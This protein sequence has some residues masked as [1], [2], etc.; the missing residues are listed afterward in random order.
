MTSPC[1]DTSVTFAALDLGEELRVG[2]G[3]APAVV[4]DLLGDD[5]V[6]E[7]QA[8]RDVDQ[9]AREAPALAALPVALR[10]GAVGG[11]LGALDAPG[12][13]VRLLGPLRRGA[14]GRR[15]VHA[16]SEWSMPG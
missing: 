6:Q 16:L 14:A 3:L 8:E 12:G 9:P 13:L 5:E 4:R 11:T 10:A 15:F 2:D 1:D 7:Q